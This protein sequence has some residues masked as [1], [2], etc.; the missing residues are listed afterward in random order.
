MATCAAAQP[1]SHGPAKGTLLITGG[2]TEAPDY[3]RFVDLSGGKHANIVV[4]P[5]G[6]VTKPTE[7]ASL[8]GQYCGPKSPFAAFPDIACTVV[9]TN[10]RD[11]ANSPAF[12]APIKAATGVW[13][14]GGRH[15]RIADAY[16][17]TLTLR[18]SSSTCSIAEASSEEAPPAQRS[19]D[20]TWCVVPPF[21][22]TTPS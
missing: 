15:W 19:R 7:L 20:R 16:L 17:D 4:I 18:R 8:Q 10:D 9:Y 22:M 14:V 11:V 1:P 13:F 3:Q 2:A 6:S 12:V 21:R 5:N